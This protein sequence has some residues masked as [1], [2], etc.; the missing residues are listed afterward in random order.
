MRS[1]AWRFRR[2]ELGQT[3]AVRK[4]SQCELFRTRRVIVFVP[5]TIV[6]VMVVI[7]PNII[8]VIV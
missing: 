8:I 6:T 2:L 5:V 7:I 1:S 3:L 4:S